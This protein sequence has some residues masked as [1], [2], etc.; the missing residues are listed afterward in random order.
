M[1]GFLNEELQRAASEM[2][3][4]TSRHGLKI[5][6]KK[7]NGRGRGGGRD[8]FITTV[9]ETNFKCLSSESKEIPSASSSK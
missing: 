3:G 9:L 6:Q 7:K 5:Q 2:A 8:L 1:N 4:E